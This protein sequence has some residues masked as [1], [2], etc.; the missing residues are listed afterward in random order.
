MSVITH[1]H[2]VMCALHTRLEILEKMAEG[3]SAKKSSLN[4]RYLQTNPASHD[5]DSDHENPEITGNTE[6]N[7]LLGKLKLFFETFQ[8]S[9][10]YIDENHNEY[11]IRKRASSYY[12][13]ELPLLEADFCIYFK[14]NPQNVASRE[15]PPEMDS[16]YVHWANVEIEAWYQKDFI[17]VKIDA[18]RR[19]DSVEIYKV[20]LDHIPKLKQLLRQ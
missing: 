16:I 11:V 9:W 19:D 6:A 17:T 13:F 12:K 7:F 18:W 14:K 8:F 4:L 15:I 5:S 2:N 3:S 20:S 1:I 10:D